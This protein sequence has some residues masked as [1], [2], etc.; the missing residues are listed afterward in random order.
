MAVRALGH[1]DHVLWLDGQHLENPTVWNSPSTPLW[2]PVL[3][4]QLMVIAGVLA[5][6]VVLLGDICF[7]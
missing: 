7:C 2:L 6:H 4:F 5:Y 3:I 1:H